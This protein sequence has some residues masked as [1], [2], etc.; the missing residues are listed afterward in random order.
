M[1]VEGE[2]YRGSTVYGGSAHVD[3]LMDAR[4]HRRGRARA[5]DFAPGDLRRL[6]ETVGR[7]AERRRPVATDRRD[8]LALVVHELATN[9]I[10]HGGG[11]GTRAHL[12]RA[13]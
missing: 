1:M 6:R 2:G 5:C 3:D 9:S 8:D 7:W 11:A 10:R 13:R 4:C 12:A